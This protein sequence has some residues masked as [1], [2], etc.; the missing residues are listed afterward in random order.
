V[1]YLSL[2]DRERSAVLEGKGI[3]RA[4]AGVHAGYAETSEM[5]VA[6][7]NLVRMEKAEKGLDDDAFYDPKNIPRSQIDSFIYGIRH[8]TDVGVLGDPVGAE[9]KLGV[10]LLDMT[11]DAFAEAIRSAVEKKS[12]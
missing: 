1:D 11:A 4:K 5:L 3:S 8:F 2:K 7:P 9:G 12:G 10:R 6:R